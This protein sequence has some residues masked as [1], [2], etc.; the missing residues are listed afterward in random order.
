MIYRCHED[1]RCR[2]NLIGGIRT[3]LYCEMIRYGTY[4]KEFKMIDKEYNAVMALYHLPDIQLNK[5]PVEIPAIEDGASN[6]SK[7]VRRWLNRPRCL[8]GMGTIG[9]L[10]PI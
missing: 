9:F 6:F 1:V 10:H 3:D 2:L 4:K 8:P 7:R 5:N